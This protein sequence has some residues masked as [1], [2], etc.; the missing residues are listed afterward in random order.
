MFGLCGTRHVSQIVAAEDWV[1][2]NVKQF[3][4]VLSLIGKYTQNTLHTFQNH[5]LPETE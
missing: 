5:L 4:A 3:I 2:P 1:P